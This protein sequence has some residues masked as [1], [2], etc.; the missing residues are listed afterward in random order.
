MNE[1]FVVIDLET[2]DREPK[3]AHVVEWAA[4]KITP[5]WF[6]AG[7]EHFYTSLVKPPIAI[8]AETSA[9]HH[10]TDADVAT[11]PRGRRSRST[12]PSWSRRTA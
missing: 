9:I 1:A 11:A 12:S 10:I 8:P 4:I 5:P 3:N 2:T 6:G 7:G